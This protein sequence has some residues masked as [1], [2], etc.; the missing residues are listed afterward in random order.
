MATAQSSE[1]GTSVAA[2]DPIWDAMRQEAST[3]IEQEP[4]LGGFIYKIVLS[5]D[6][7]E[8]AIIQRVVQRLHSRDLDA[9]TILQ[10]FRKA[11]DEQPGIGRAF[12]A[13]LAAVFDRDP[14]C[15][16]YIEPLLY[17]KGFHALVVYRL[18]HALW[19]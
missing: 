16:R 11:I 13:D 17:F 7:L 3:A 9:A 18:A 1:P 8:E 4:A 6:T 2:L 12:R 19:L 10:A 14:A 15:S 5:S